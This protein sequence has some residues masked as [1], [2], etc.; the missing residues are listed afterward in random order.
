MQ[1]HLNFCGNISLT[2]GQVDHPD[3]QLLNF[4]TAK[5]VLIQFSMV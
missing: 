2:N 4:E 3:I 5:A 1:E